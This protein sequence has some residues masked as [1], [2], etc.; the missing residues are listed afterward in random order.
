MTTDLLTA[1]FA[2]GLVTALVTL[3]VTRKKRASE[4]TEAT[5]SAADAIS[6]AWARLMAPMETRVKL[7]ECESESK[8]ADIKALQQKVSELEADVR[9]R[10]VA[11]ETLQKRIRELQA[12]SDVK[13][14]VI[15][16]QAA[17]IVM[18]EVKVAELESKLSK[19]DEGKKI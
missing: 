14:G 3:F 6:E 18:L 2:S 10:Q 15:R 4:V 1:A 17:Q 5:A 19:L 11:I 7:L 16:D 9:S 13:D 8:N 12:A